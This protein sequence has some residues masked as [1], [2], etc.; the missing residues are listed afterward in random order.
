ERYRETDYARDSGERAQMLLRRGKGVQ[1]SKLRRAPSVFNRQ[2]GSE[3]PQESGGAGFDRQCAAQKQQVPGLHCLD[4]RAQR[5]WGMRQVELELFQTFF[6]SRIRNAGVHEFLR[7]VTTDHSVQ[8][9]PTSSVQLPPTGVRTAVNVQH[10]A[11]D[12]ARFRQVE[13]GFGD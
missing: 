1:G 9:P 2:L 11:G 8:L 5:L 3:T 10:F 13:D 12:R 4:I 7:A 6:G